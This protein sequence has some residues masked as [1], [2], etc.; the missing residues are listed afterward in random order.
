[1]K[2]LILLATFVTFSGLAQADIQA[3][4]GS[5]YTSMRKLGRGISNVLYGV[6]ELP[7]GMVRRSDQ[8]GRKAGWS[9][10]IVDGTNKSLRRYRNPNNM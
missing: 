6:M 7:E 3:P 9:Y 8:L 2:Y 10:G 1:M 5:Q 4:P